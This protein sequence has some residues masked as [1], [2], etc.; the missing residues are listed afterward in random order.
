MVSAIGHPAKRLTRIRFGCI[1]LD[2]L[3]EGEVRQLTPHEIKVLL[4][5]AKFDHEQ[6]PKK[7]RIYS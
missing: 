6:V 1:T 5:D 4:N 3:A 7:V 2:G